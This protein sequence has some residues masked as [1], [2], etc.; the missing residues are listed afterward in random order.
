MRR[1]GD[2]KR[3]GMNWRLPAIGLG[4][5]LLTLAVLAFLSEAVGRG[6]GI[7]VAAVLVVV[8]ALLLLLDRPR[9]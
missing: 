1:T 8:T 6:T 2:V 4:F 3:T 5:A 7:A 9:K